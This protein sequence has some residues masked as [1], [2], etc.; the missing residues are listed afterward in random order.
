MS[1]CIKTIFVDKFGRQYTV[2]LKGGGNAVLFEDGFAIYKG[3][4]SQI[5]TMGLVP[6]VETQK[7]IAKVLTQRIR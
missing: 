7:N 5:R 6:K 1:Q 3:T 2:E 4:V